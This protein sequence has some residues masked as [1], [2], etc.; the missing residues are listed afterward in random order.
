MTNN[1]N[2]YVSI[3]NKLRLFKGEIQHEDFTSHTSKLNNYNTNWRWIKKECNMRFL[4]ANH[5]STIDSHPNT[6]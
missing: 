3:P 6:L 4:R 1:N 2:N 5:S